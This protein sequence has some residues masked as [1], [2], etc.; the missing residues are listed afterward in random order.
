M[1]VAHEYSHL[2]GA[3]I[4]QVRYP[5][6]D[7]EIREAIA[8]VRIRRTEVGKDKRERMPEIPYSL[9][10]MNQQFREAFGDRGYR[11]LPRTCE[12]A[13]LNGGFVKGRVLVEVQLTAH[14][15]MFYDTAKFQYFFTEDE[16]EVGV[17]IVPSPA[18]YQQILSG[19]E[20]VCDI[21][22]IKRH[23]PVAPMKVILID[24]DE[25]D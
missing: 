6:I 17:E 5:D 24:T 3:E 13:K 16:A 18:L 19:E 22:Q 21:E 7:R 12:P 20:L 2:G 4:L 10:S 11:E 1:R 15:V 14:F 8:E 9:V 25:P 23:L